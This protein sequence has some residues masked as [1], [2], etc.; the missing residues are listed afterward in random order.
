MFFTVAAFRRG[1]VVGNSSAL[2]RRDLLVS[3]DVERIADALDDRIERVAS[4]AAQ[5]T[6]VALTHKARQA[7]DPKPLALEAGDLPLR[8][9]L[10]HRGYFP[11]R[12]GARVYLREYDVLGRR[13]G[14]SK[15][16]YF[17]AL[18]K[19]YPSAR[20]AAREEAFIGSRKGSDWLARRFLRLAFRKT[21]YKPRGVSARPVRFGG[22]DTAG[23]QFF[24]RA[25]KGRFEGVELSVRRGRVANSILVM[26]LARDVEPND[27][28]ALRGKLR[29][30]LR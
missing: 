7:P 18:G 14:G 30:R 16:F 8:T 27:L 5:R 19:V 2:L 24:Y 17:R 12:G 15:I 22:A 3:G 21:D 11:V 28:L 4:G 1:R 26:G 29:A 20:A 23:F 9:A 6:P 25:P 10:A 13:L